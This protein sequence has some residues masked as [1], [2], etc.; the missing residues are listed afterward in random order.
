MLGVGESGG[1]DVP[2][3]AAD[4]SLPPQPAKVDAITAAP[5][6]HPAAIRTLIRIT[7][8]SQ[9]RTA[10]IAAVG[11]EL[12]GR[13]RFSC[14][15]HVDRRLNRPGTPRRKP[16]CALGDDSSNRN[17]LTKRPPWPRPSESR[18]RGTIHRN[19]TIDNDSQ[20]EQR[21]RAVAGSDL[22]RASPHG[23][24]MNFT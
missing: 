18:T 14:G 11:P 13:Q 1:D 15:G 10:V 2:L 7:A 17:S 23:V 24:T 6:S 9:V 12:G 21:N 5:P 19:A 8:S 3:G 20:S 22:Q 16:D 4:G